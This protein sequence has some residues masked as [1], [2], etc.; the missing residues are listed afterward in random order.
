M[1]RAS[2]DEVHISHGR[3]WLRDITNF[4]LSNVGLGF[5]EG[6]GARSGMQ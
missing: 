4:V 6:D 3:F 5:K 2:T 1:T